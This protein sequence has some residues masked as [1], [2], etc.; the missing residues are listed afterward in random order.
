LPS[1]R[2]AVPRSAPASTPTP[3]SPTR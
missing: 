2:S 1:C 3:T